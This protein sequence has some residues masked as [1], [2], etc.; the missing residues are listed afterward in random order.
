M[1]KLFLQSNRPGVYFRVVEEGSVT[2]GDA[3]ERIKKASDCITVMEINRAFA[4]GR[5]NIPLM[6]RLVRHPFLPE[7][8]RD[9]F[10]SQLDLIEES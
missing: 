4:H 8:F 9:H 10:L 3:V 6:R 5:E 7:G 2:N 1:V